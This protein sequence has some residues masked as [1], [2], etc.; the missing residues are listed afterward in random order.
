MSDS[1][2]P[3]IATR[4]PCGTSVLS[5]RVRSRA[6]LR[7]DARV[8]ALEVV[9]VQDATDVDRVPLLRRAVLLGREELLTHL[10]R[11][12]HAEVVADHAQHL[13][14]DVERVKIGRA[15]V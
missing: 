4:D 15:H 10:P 13:S 14:G 12:V 11:A 1:A 8:L 3:T 2:A 6:T 5:F 9:A 7:V